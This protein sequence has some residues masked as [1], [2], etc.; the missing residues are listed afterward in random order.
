MIQRIIWILRWTFQN[1]IYLRGGEEHLAKTD[2]YKLL[3]FSMLL[4]STFVSCR[5]F[6]IFATKLYLKVSYY[7]LKQKIMDYVNTG[8]NF[9]ASALF[10]FDRIINVFQQVLKLK[11]F[12]D[13]LQMLRRQNVG[14]KNMNKVF[15]SVQL[16]FFWDVL[17]DYKNSKKLFRYYKCISN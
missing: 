15:A 3:Y 8:R 7:F 11:E 12:Y 9:C 6:D 4:F 1:L 10:N 2:P 5:Q 16:Q 13:S 14:Y 17:L